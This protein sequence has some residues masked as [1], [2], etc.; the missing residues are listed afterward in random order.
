MAFY[1]KSGKN[2]MSIPTIAAYTITVAKGYKTPMN[3]R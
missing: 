3:K 2:C 1:V